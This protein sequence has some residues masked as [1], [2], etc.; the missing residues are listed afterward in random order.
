MFN[1]GLKSYYLPGKKISYHTSR[2]NLDKEI[3]S[4]SQAQIFNPYLFMI[5]FQ[6]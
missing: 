2:F 5:Q 3:E 4:L 1:I 6:T